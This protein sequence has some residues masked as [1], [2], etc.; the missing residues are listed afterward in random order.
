MDRLTE[1]Q[2]AQ[3]TDAE[4]E[5]YE[6]M[7]AEDEDEGTT[8]EGAEDN[9]DEDEAR[10]DDGASVDDEQDDEGGADDEADSGEQEVDDAAQT[11]MAPKLPPRIRPKTHKLMKPSLRQPPSRLISTPRDASKLKSKPSSRNRP[12]CSNSSMTGRSLARN[13]LRRTRNF[14]PSSRPS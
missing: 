7:L 9:D 5:G 1:E 10:D 3:L 12:S 6:L 2:L 8:D 13:F 4:R 11:R 14:A